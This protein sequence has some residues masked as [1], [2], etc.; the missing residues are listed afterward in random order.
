MRNKF[1]VE[2]SKLMKKAIIAKFRLI[3]P[4]FIFLPHF[5]VNLHAFKVFNVFHS[6]HMNPFKKTLRFSKNLIKM[7]KFQY[8]TS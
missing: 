3:M 5:I 2:K 7:R 1:R 4:N 6:M 8:F